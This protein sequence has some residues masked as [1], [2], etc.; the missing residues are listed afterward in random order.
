M[1]TT[2]KLLLL[3][4]VIVLLSGVFIALLCVQ[5]K[6]GVILGGPYTYSEY[7]RGKKQRFCEVPP[8]LA[9]EIDQWLLCGRW[10]TIDLVSYAPG[11]GV[12]SENFHLNCIGDTVVLNYKRKPDDKVY[13]QYSCLMD[14][15]ILGIMKRI[16]DQE[17]ND[18]E[19]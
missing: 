10:W 15:V 14:D 5:R 12:R 16:S 3:L 7:I 4:L 18:R 9:D 13:L 1:S 19:Q 11:Q 6:P 2:K 17:S 8:D